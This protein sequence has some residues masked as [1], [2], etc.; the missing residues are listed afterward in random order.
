[1][2][3]PAII[4]NYMLCLSN[5]RMQNFFLEFLSRTVPALRVA[6]T[7]VV[8][9]KKVLIASAVASSVLTSFYV[10]YRRKEAKEDK[11]EDKE[12][13]EEKKDEESSTTF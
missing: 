6:R 8:R 1:M 3:S 2:G 7:V 9:M 13:K 12:E 10:F 11:K 4:N 5:F